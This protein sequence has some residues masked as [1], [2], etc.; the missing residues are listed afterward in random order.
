MIGRL[1]AKPSVSSTNWKPGFIVGGPVYL[2][3]DVH[4]GKIKALLA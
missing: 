2:R 3:S 1:P 4:I